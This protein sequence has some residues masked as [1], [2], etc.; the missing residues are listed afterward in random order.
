MYLIRK[1]GTTL[2]SL[3]KE[4]IYDRRCLGRTRFKAHTVVEDETWIFVREVL[5]V[6]VRL[7]NAI[8]SDIN[9]DLQSFQR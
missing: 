7:S 8:I 2:G 4:G 1:F 3:S 9:G 6:D 5:V